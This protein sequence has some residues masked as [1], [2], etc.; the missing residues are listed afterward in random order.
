MTVISIF[1]RTN[2]IAIFL[3]GP[4]SIAIMVFLFLLAFF[5]N[6]QRDSWTNLDIA[7]TFCIFKKD[8]KIIDFWFFHSIPLY[9][10]I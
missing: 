5:R 2:M 3:K 4:K 10:I 6:H 7:I 1:N 8:R 9:L